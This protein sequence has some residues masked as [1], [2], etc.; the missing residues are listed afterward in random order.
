MICS[1]EYVNERFAQ[2]G[3]GFVFCQ[4]MIFRISKLDTENMHK[5]RF[6]LIKK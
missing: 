1:V 3:G 4:V 2:L 6:D 5:T